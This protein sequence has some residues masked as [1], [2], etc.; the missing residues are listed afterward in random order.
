MTNKSRRNDV[1]GLHPLGVVIAVTLAL[2]AGGC[3]SGRRTVV[4][5]E[6]AGA[7]A[8][9]LEQARQACAEQPVERHSNATRRDRVAAD[10][11]GNA[12]VKCMEE[13]G[14]T[15]KTRDLNE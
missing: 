10:A 6:K 2:L 13:R 1:G 15:W 5:W 14:W 11:M 8:E 4:V 3:A 9:E 12:F 7:S